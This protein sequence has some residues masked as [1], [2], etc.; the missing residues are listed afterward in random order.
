MW[1]N[2]DVDGTGGSGVDRSG[3]YVLNS[4]NVTIRNSRIHGRGVFA[5]R[6]IRKGT[7]PARSM[8]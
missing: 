3:I 5:A 6:R 2:I 7:D 1:E 8:T 4:R